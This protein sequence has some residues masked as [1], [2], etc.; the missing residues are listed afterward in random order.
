LALSALGRGGGKPMRAG[1][2]GESVPSK[3]ERSE[4]SSEDSEN[5]KRPR[6][7]SISDMPRDQT[8]DFT[9]YWAPCIRSG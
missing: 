2:L 5:G 8:S 9:V 4:S 1:R 6:A 3:S 7:S